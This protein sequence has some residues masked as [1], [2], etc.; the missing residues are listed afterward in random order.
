MS[1]GGDSGFVKAETHFCEVQRLTG[2]TQCNVVDPCQ[3][4][5]F[6]KG[7]TMGGGDRVREKVKKRIK[8]GN[9]KRK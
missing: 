3:G 7:E 9:E 8:E 1:M 4:E 6:R 5:L 2:S